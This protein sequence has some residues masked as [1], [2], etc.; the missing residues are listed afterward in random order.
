V[1]AADTTVVVAAAASWHDD[2]A[3]ARSAIERW[4]PR[5]VGHVAVETYSVLTR[6]PRPLRVTASAAH[7]FLTEEFGSPPLILSAMGY[8]E[9]IEQA[10]EVGIV[11]GALYDAL[12]GATAR[13][14][15]AS[16]LTLDRRAA[17]IY[18]RL[19]VD[20]RFVG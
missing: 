4:K 10:A 2:H 8:R 16:L 13:E 15:G 17:V 18:Q 12:V 9:L 6:L 11:G 20:Y 1:I 3:T 7:E 19:G 14:A 5:L